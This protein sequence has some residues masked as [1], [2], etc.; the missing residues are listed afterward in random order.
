ME[1]KELEKMKPFFT[2][3][4]ITFDRLER[5]INNH[6]VVIFHSDYYESYYYLK[7]RSLYDSE[8]NFKTVFK[9]EVEIAA[10]KQGLL[11]KDSLID[12]TQIYKISEK[13]MEKV[14][15]KKNTLFLN[16]DFFNVNE[17]IQIYDKLQNNFKEVPPFI[18]LSHIT[19]NE[20]SNE[21]KA[22]TL[23]SHKDLLDIEKIHNLKD[24][25]LKKEIL[26][27]RNKEEKTLFEIK[28]IN[29]GLRHSKDL[30][31]IRLDNIKRNEKL[32]KTDYLDFITKNNIN[33][34]EYNLAQQNE[35]IRG[36]EEGLSKNEVLI[37]TDVKF[38]S[39]QM[40]QIIEGIKNKINIFLYLDPNLSWKEMREIRENLEEKKKLELEQESEEDF[41]MTM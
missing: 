32:F 7:C 10:K 40:R 31:L 36:F 23:Y 9:G 13:D 39:P 8:G 25:R 5:N 3:T 26:D 14:F 4:S 38:Q 21:V 27:L 1:N 16:T 20:T 28:D 19:V 17:I 24:N 12:T 6:P 22:K 15:N 30:F 18:S 33:I 2:D 11:T 37:Y 34:K 41:G 35:I 29:A